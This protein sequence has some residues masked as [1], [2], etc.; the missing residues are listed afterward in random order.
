MTEE[1]LIEIRHLIF[2][3]ENIPFSI[4]WDRVTLE[5]F[6]K[7]AIKNPEDGI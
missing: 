6:K 1:E 7:Y 4:G 5:I 2:R 3:M